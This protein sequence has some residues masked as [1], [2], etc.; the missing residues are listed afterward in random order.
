MLEIRHLKTLIALAETGNLS[1]AARRIH[2]SQPA[3]SHQIRGIEEAYQ[4]ELFE[5]KSDP[6]KLTAAGQLLVEL[7]YDVIR[8]IENGER[9][10]ARIAQG[11]AGELRI[12]V[13]CHSCFDW[14]MPSMDAFREHWPQVEMDLVSGFHADPV[15]LLSENRADLVIVSHAQ[16]REGVKFH[17]LFSYEVLAL[18]SR[19][20]VLARKAYVTASDFKNETL[21]TY[22]IPD[23]RL[24]IVREVLR[25]AK[26]DPPRR[27]TELTVAI[28]Q[29]VA[30]GRGIAALPGW[31]VQPFL[32]RNYV[33][34]RP[35]GKKGLHSRLYAATTTAA[36]ELAYMQEFIRIMR[37]VS[38]ATLKGIKQI[39]RL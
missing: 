20:H 1:K 25:P 5:R 8:R 27:K 15:G 24:D 3:V 26:M 6:L 4:V 22:P 39:E 23:D 34:G 33:V 17:P 13:E 31:T 38:F 19:H 12:A 28:L 37:D 29:L 18:V 7:A 35:I 11:Q 9:D 21:V 14:L 36:A 2:L 32:D 16:K 30:S 10:L